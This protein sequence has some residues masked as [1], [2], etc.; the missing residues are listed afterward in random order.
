M[1][2]LD[3]S[4]A[5]QIRTERKPVNM[6]RIRVRRLIVRQAGLALLIFVVFLF[7]LIWLADV[8]RG[9]WLFDLVRVVPGGDKTGHFILFGLLSLLV[10]LVFRAAVVRVGKLS[11]LKGTLVVAVFAIAEE[12]SQLLFVSRTF[13]LLDLSAGLLG[14][15]VFGW[16]ARRSVKPELASSANP[17]SQ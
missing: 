2:W 8:G 3:S 16:L 1:E 5:Q 4:V 11:V 15:W 17:L 7:T 12:C 9:Q 10:N 6:V 13:D 14:I